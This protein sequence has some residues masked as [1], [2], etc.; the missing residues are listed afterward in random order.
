MNPAWHKGKDN[1]REFKV[2]IRSWIN[3]RW[4]IDHNQTTVHPTLELAQEAAADIEPGEQAW[5]SEVIEIY[6]RK[7]ENN[8][9]TE[10]DCELPEVQRGDGD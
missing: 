4:Y 7:D 5:I 6:E 8:Q 10:R 9:E 2:E 3:D 1:F